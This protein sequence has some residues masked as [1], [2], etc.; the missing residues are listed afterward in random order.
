MFFFFLTGSSRI[1]WESSDIILDFAE[2]RRPVCC[3]ARAKRKALTPKPPQ[4]HPKQ[5]F[6]ASSRA[7]RPHPATFQCLF[8]PCLQPRGFFF[9]RVALPRALSLPPRCLFP[10]PVTSCGAP[11]GRSEAEFWRSVSPGT[12]A[13]CEPLESFFPCASG[14]CLERL[15]GVPPRQGERGGTVHAVSMDTPEYSEAARA[16]REVFLPT[17]AA[18]L[19]CAGL[20]FPCS[21]STKLFLGDF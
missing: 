18:F 4:I 11:A 2:R 12:Q 14:L 20:E 16:M 13:V 10:H 7:T 5:V 17:T 3:R 9:Y 21:E 8:S 19:T 6:M 15:P 1:G